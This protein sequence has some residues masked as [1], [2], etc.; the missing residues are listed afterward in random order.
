MKNTNNLEKTLIKCHL[1]NIFLSCIA[2]RPLYVSSASDD[3][4]ADPE[5]EYISCV[6]ASVLQFLEKYTNILP[7]HQEINKP[8]INGYIGYHIHDGKHELRLYDWIQ[9]IK[10]VN[11]QLTNV[12]IN[13]IYINIILYL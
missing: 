10:F 13:Y 8:I 12:K 3:V 11:N 2:P 6:L 1:I 5:G 4:N 9:Y 7:N